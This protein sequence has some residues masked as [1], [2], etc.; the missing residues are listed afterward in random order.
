M[1]SAITLCLQNCLVILG[2]GARLLSRGRRGARVSRRGDFFNPD[3]V[4]DN[5][6]VGLIRELNNERTALNFETAQA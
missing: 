2:L 5:L 1:D 3:C 4:G 6:T